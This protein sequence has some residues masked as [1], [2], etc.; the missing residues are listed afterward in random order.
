MPELT[1]KEFFQPSLLD[2]LTDNEPD[3]QREDMG[4]RVLTVEA[5]REIVLRDLDW[6]LN[7][8][9]SRAEMEEFERFPRAAKSVAA[10]GIPALSGT[11]LGTIDTV[12]LE[13]QVRDAV[14]HFEPRVLA[15]SLKVR[16]NSNPDQMDH[17]ALTFEIEGDLLA[18]PLPERLLLKYA[19]DLETGK[20]EY[21]DAESS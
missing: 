6:L 18:Q 13:K 14:Q 4:R 5:L 8:P 7:N 12:E 3:K 11:T 1:P 21:R 17:N 15:S 9:R 20:V 16:V 10:F 19:I 2:R